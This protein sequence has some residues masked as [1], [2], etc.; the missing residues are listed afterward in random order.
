MLHDDERH[1]PV[2]IYS[3]GRQRFAEGGL[4]SAAEDVRGAGRYGDEMVVHINRREFDEMRERWGDPHI[5][6]ETGLPEFFDLQD[7]WDDA[8][9]TWNDVKVYAV[10]AAA[11]AAGAFLPQIGGAVSTFLPGVGQF[12]GDTG[13]QALATGL[14]GAGAGYLT[15]GGQ[16]ALLGG[17]AGA[18]GAYGG[19][20]FRNGVDASAI[21][22]ILAKTGAG[23]AGAAGAAGGAGGEGA[24]MGG[25][26]AIP[27]LLMAGLN[28][29]QSAFGNEDEAL[30]T[31]EG[32]FDDAQSQNNKPLPTWENRRKRKSYSILPDYTQ[33]GERE[34][35]EDN[36]LDGTPQYA[37]G[38]QVY[39]SFGGEG[40]V[41]HGRSDDVEALLSENE[42][43]IDAETVA[44][45]GNGS[46]EAGAE[47]LDRMRANIRKHKGSALSAGA[48]S[49]DALSPEQYLEA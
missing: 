23:A 18:A 22:Q 25:S 8:K 24:G 5:N 37:D 46:P 41:S 36:S 35:F 19:D 10:P 3:G 28:M 15:N 44:L 49:P 21:G 47:R 45:L 39:G 20:L 6:P 11:A 13:T 43:V 31:A 1:L 26:A 42:Y 34:Y 9:D 2:K 38:G 4:A 14:L 7:V 32:N 29:A 48:I 33:E 40:E 30:A 27:A 16:G 17:L 12:L